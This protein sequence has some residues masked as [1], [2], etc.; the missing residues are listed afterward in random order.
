MGDLSL[1]LV[2]EVLFGLLGGEAGDALQHFGLAALDKLDLLGFLVNGG[3]LL[4]QGLFFLFHGL[5]LTVEVFLLL[6]QAVFLPLKVGPAFLDFLFV[7]AAVF[8]NLF[9]GFQQSL[10][11]FGFGAFDGLVDN[12]RS[13]FLGAGD[14]FFRDVLPV[15]NTKREANHAAGHQPYDKGDDVLNHGC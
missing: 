12:A 13:L 8:Q 5:D 15:A 4:G 14:F 10:A 7:L 2:D 1:H 9:L 6:L 11:L 3:V